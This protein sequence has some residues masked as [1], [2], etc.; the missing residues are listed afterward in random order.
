MK[1][2]YT[3][4]Y[5]L[6]VWGS[7]LLALWFGYYG[8]TNSSGWSKALWLLGA[9]LWAIQSLRE[10]RRR[11]TAKRAGEDPSLIRIVDDAPN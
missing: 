4:N 11:I 6:T 9:T 2:I 10:L 8:L 3:D 5:A 7:A 1:T